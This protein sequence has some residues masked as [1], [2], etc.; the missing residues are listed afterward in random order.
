MNRQSP[1]PSRILF[2]LATSLFCVGLLS[3]TPA[4]AQKTIIKLGWTTSDGAQDP[5]AVGARAFKSA[6]ERETRGT[7]EVQLF[8]NRQLGDELPTKLRLIVC[9]TVTWVRS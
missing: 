2:G 6:V 3:T 4:L 8:P 5:Y 1:S 9:W 7:V